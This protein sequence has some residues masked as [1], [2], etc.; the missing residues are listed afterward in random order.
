MLSRRQP[1]LQLALTDNLIGPVFSSAKA[2]RNVITRKFSSS[3]RNESDF[4]LHVKWQTARKALQAGNVGV[5][6][7]PGHR[8]I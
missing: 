6:P 4:P 8:S 3:I 2:V 1:F 5:A 7:G